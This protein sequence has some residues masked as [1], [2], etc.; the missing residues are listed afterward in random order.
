MVPASRMS[1]ACSAARRAGTSSGRL[2]DS[3]AS[4][5]SSVLDGLQIGQ[6]QLGVDGLDVVG[7]RDAPVDMDDV[8]VGEHPD[9]LAD[10]IAL[11]NGG[12]ELVAQAL[13]LRRPLHDA[14]DVHE[15]DGGRHDLRALEHLGQPLQAL[16]GHGHHAHVGVD[17]GK[18][19]VGGQNLVTGQGVEQGGLPHVGEADD[20][21]GQ[22]H[23]Y[24]LR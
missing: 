18:G 6:D 10:G 21:D 16:V 11:A 2:R 17:G 13:P 22:S 23:A 5:I 1:R 3:L 19:I 14:G 20:A 8:R 9:H 7:R 12:Q 24:F 4:G 15:G